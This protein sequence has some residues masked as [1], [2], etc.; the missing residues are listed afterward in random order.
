MGFDKKLSIKERI[1]K[2][3]RQRRKRAFIFLF[4][5]MI[6]IMAFVVINNALNHEDEELVFSDKGPVQ[7]TF[8]IPSVV[9]PTTAAIPAGVGVVSS[10]STNDEVAAEKNLGTAPENSIEE[11][12]ENMRDKE[13]SNYDK[14]KN[15]LEK[16]IAGC[17]GQYGICY[18]DLI[19]DYEFG[20]NATDEYIAASTVKVPLN[21]F[22]YKKIASGGV[23][24]EKTLEYN[25]DDFEDGTG[26]LQSKKLSGNSF[27]IRYLL[28][29]S[30]THSDNIATNML[31]R[32]FGRKNLKNYMRT[33]GGTVV[34]DN[35]NVSCPKDMAIYLKNIYDFCNNNGE[36]GE[37]LKY[38]L[39]NTMFNDRLPK[40]LPKD[41]EVAHKVGDQIQ[42]V[43]DVGI[44]YA[45]KPYVLTIMSKGVVS[46]E[47]AH[48]VIAQISKKV[49]DYVK[50][51]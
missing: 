27:T 29:L 49:Y 5:L 6:S 39:C 15:E 36:L 11:N 45:D 30:I 41:V 1:K 19:N 47:E 44:I 4:F 20:I 7:S 50:D 16:Y 32:Y 25:S 31:L 46:D 43:H 21:Y 40:L 26:I 37:E 9:E 23:D 12:V 28:K 3:R 8:Q 33:L 42:A 14:L 38:N 2:R 34:E 18:I 24:P 22:V 13:N 17:K 35:K 10:I 51:R 48:N